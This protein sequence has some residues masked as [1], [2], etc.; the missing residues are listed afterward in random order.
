[1]VF[2][3]VSQQVE[4]KNTIKQIRKSTCQKLSSCHFFPS[5]FLYRVFGRF[6]ARGA[7]KHHTNIF[8]NNKTRKS[9][10]KRQKRLVSV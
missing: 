7:Q 2:L 1:M 6:S 9:L 10:K 3:C 8:F 5:I 4:F